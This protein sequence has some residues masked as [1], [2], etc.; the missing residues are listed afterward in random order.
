MPAIMIRTHLRPH[1]M[2]LQ[3]L[4]LVLPSVTISLADIRFICDLVVTKSNGMPL[5]TPLAVS[6]AAA[7]ISNIRYSLFQRPKVQLR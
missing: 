3:T 2:M 4:S 1:N 5:T 7:P 6:Q